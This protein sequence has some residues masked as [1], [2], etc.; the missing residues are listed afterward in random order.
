MRSE[1]SFSLHQVSLTSSALSNMSSESLAPLRSSLLS[2]DLSANSLSSLP[3]AL[4]GLI[5]L[6]HLD[7]SDNRISALD[8]RVLN[9]LSRWGLYNYIYLICKTM[10]WAY[11]DTKAIDGA[12]PHNKHTEM[13]K[14]MSQ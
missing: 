11:V 3:T 6:R 8:S 12:P 13:L 14:A 7:L 2:L 1:V 5:K 9:S 4:A 10:F